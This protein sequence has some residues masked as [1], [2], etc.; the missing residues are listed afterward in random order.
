MIGPLEE[1]EDGIYHVSEAWEADLAILET[2]GR[3]HWPRPA[4]GH[5]EEIRSRRQH[6]SEVQGRSHHQR[7]DQ[8][9]K[10]LEQV[11]FCPNYGSTT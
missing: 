8:K 7:M 10:R 2:G 11:S 3:G 1:R 6:R 5:Q 4:K 9:L